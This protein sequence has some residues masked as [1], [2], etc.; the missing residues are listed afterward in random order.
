MLESLSSEN[1]VIGK[2]TYSRL[3]F[4]LAVEQEAR[5]KSGNSFVLY[6]GKWTGTE[7]MCGRSASCLASE[8]QGTLCKLLLI[9]ELHSVRI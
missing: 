3:H 8:V 1:F 2:L 5:P 6:T 7:S 9:R 4:K